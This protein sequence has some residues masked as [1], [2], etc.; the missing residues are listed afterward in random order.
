MLAK[1]GRGRPP[2]AATSKSVGRKAGARTPS[3]A[4]RIL[5]LATGKTRQQLYVAYPGDYP[6]H[7]CLAVQRHI[8]AGRIRATSAQI[9]LRAT[10][11]RGSCRSGTHR[12]LFRRNCCDRTVGSTMNSGG[13]S[14][15][16]ENM[17]NSVGDRSARSVGT[18]CALLGLHQQRQSERSTELPNN[19]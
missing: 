6:N 17:A 8:G 10:S 16:V 7:V 2:R 4:E 15:L 5:A 18:D 1:Q 9:G 19:V 12:L 3:L 14:G 13:Y 11:V